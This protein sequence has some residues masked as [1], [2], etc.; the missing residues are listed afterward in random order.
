MKGW[1]VGAQ[2]EQETKRKMSDSQGMT[3]KDINKSNN[4]D[5]TLGNIKEMSDSRSMTLTRN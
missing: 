1:T 2:Y 4:Q 3:L 5:I